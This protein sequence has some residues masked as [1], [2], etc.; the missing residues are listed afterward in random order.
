MLAKK[1]FIHS[2]IM[3]RFSGGTHEQVYDWRDDLLKNLDMYD[4]LRMIGVRPGS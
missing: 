3:M 1:M 4:D 2:K